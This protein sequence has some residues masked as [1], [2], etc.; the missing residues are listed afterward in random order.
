M[1]VDAGS[2]RGEEKECYLSCLY[3]PPHA[4]GAHLLAGLVTAR[5]EHSRDGVGI[6]DWAEVLFT[7][8]LQGGEWRVGEGSLHP[9]WYLQI[10]KMA[11]A[12]VALHSPGRLL[13]PGQMQRS[14]EPTSAPPGPAPQY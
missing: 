1:L 8:G 13:P 4:D 2:V 11:C 3:S 12:P 10:V 7:G 5:L 9:S 6:A 14:G